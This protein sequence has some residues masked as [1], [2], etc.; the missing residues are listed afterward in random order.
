MSLLFAIILIARLKNPQ[1]YKYHI[2]I[3][4]LK[5]MQILRND[6]VVSKTEEYSTT[7]YRPNIYMTYSWHPI[8][9][10]NSVLSCYP[11]TST[12]YNSLICHLNVIGGE[13][14]K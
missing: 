3:L 11:V 8:A 12:H 1:S 2:D 6:K 13:R 10:T 9:I 4:L 14:L 5:K 7:D